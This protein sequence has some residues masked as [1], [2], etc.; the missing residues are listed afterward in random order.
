M[1]FN[2]FE[3]AISAIVGAGSAVVAALVMSFRF[4]SRLTEIENA[5]KEA[6]TKAEKNST[7]LEALVKEQGESWQEFNRTLGQIEGA[8]G[9]G[10]PPTNPRGRYP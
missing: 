10:Q 9:L 5:A 7:D 4:G 6:K 8:I 3:A 1:D 2:V